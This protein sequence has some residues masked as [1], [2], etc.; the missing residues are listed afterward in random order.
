[1]KRDLNRLS[2]E[3]FDLLIIGG[4]IHGATIAWQAALENFKVA[5]VEQNDFASGT[6]SNSQKII[7]GGLRYLSSF[8]LSR[9][10]QSLTERTRLM[11]IAPHLVNPLPC[12]IPVYQHGF[13]GKEGMIIG[14]K[15]YDYLSKDG[16][17]LPDIE[18]QIP[19]CEFLS[20]NKVLKIIPDLDSSK[21]VGG[22]KWSDG[23][24]FNTER[25]IISF[26][27]SAVKFGALAANY[28]CVEKLLLNGNR[29]EGVIAKDNLTGQGF[30][31]RSENVIDCTGTWINKYLYNDKMK[32]S[33]PLISGINIITRKLFDHDLAIGLTRSDGK[34]RYYFI[35]PWGEKSIVG[36]EWF[37][38]HNK[39]SSFEVS[40]DQCR[41]FINNVNSVYPSLKLKLEDAL[42]VHKGNVFGEKTKNDPS[43]T[44]SDFKI[45]DSESHAIAGLF[46][47]IGVKYTTAA[48]IAEEIIRKINPSIKRKKILDQPKLIGGEIDNLYKFKTE[49]QSKFNK[50][51]EANELNSLIHN[52][53]TEITNIVNPIHE[54]KEKED[55]IKAKTIFSIKEEMANTLSDVILRRTEIGTSEMPQNSVIDLIAN[56]MANELG[57]NEEKKKK[58][59]SQLMNH[60]PKFIHKL[61]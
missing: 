31:L 50:K 5:I 29:V 13:K 34:S 19:N 4:G 20:N 54:W 41:Q 59:I 16:I 2:N 40:E 48:Y 21:L 39:E 46:N 14:F 42:Y 36:T 51:I 18:K 35:A 30:S 49:I 6:S 56:A 27:K 47:V 60:Y 26:I 37:Y 11:W 10:K 22:A 23:F 8:N 28:V 38:E 45:I 32:Y 17:E 57:W 15:I 7:H 1:L 33:Y 52:Y 9:I 55:V 43:A 44:L 53:G 12:V 24:C 58:E 3:K 25:L 61:S